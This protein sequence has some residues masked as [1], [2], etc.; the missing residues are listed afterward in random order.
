VS[1]GNSDPLR[2]ERPASESV[3]ATAEIVRLEATVVGRVQGVG[4]RYFVLT[5]A[6][7]LGATG[8]VSNA[9]DG[10]VRLAAEGTSSSL[11]RL[12]R[13]LTVGPPGAEIRDV[14]LRWLAATG[15]F[16]AFVVKSGSHPGD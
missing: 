12:A 6:N 10:S 14:E 11:E 9:S 7:R 1:A 13:R 2:G 8:W 4:Y 15:S 16:G 3:D 5:E